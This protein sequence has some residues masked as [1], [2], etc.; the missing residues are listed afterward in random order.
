MKKMLVLCAGLALVSSGLFAEE[1]D[2]HKFLYY[3]PE[4]G[5]KYWS[6]KCWTE[7]DSGT[8][9]YVSWSSDAIAVVMSGNINFPQTNLLNVY[10]IQ[11]KNSSNFLSAGSGTL[12]LGAG[13][14]LLS[15]NMN[16]RSFSVN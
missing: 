5:G 8:L 4:S 12:C 3:R 14:I 11:W 15:K 2:G 13:G 7:T 6:Q 1:I 10:G 9:T 16:C